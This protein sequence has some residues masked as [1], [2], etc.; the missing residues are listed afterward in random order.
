MALITP[1]GK[2]IDNYYNRYSADD[3]Y[4][5]VLVRD[6]YVAQASEI[7]E[8]QSIINA[9]L[10]GIGDALFSDGDVIKD[11][12]ISVSDSGVVTAEAGL[13]STFPVWSGQ[14]LQRPLL[15][16]LPAQ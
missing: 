4:T 2:Q 3:H 5:E 6:G 11:G 16:R 14:F 12:Q 13:V 9:R 7:N 15:S 1:N 8:L 10:Q